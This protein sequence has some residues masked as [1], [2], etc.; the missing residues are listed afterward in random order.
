[1]HESMQILLDECILP[2][3]KRDT[4]RELQEVASIYEAHGLSPYHSL[5]FLSQVA[6]T[7]AVEA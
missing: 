4:S 5:S 3:A 2:K 7:T 1:M 6:G